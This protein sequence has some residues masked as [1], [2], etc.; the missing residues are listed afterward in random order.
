MSL[1]LI[2]IV[3]IIVYTYRVSNYVGI[4]SIDKQ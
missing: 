3:N 1:S 4:K 2:I